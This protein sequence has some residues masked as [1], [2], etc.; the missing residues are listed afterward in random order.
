M[1]CLVVLFPSCDAIEIVK[2]L[3]TSP[4]FTAQIPQGIDILDCIGGLFLN[5]FY[6]TANNLVILL[7]VC[8]RIL[9]MKGAVMVV[10]VW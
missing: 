3:L 4:T 1:E 9:F 8:Y 6:M 7:W 5:F 10:I 2:T